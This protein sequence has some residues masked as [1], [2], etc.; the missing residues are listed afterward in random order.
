[1]YYNTNYNNRF[2]SKRSENK[3]DNVKLVSQRFNYSLRT[4]REQLK[5][6]RKPFSNKEMRWFVCA[7]IYWTGS[8]HFQPGITK[9]EASA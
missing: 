2:V 7:K 9:T 8:L 3:M 1:M 5:V 4:W 6:C